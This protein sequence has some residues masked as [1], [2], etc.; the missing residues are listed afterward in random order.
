MTVLGVA[1]GIS[2][3]TENSWKASLWKG[4]AGNH[5]HG[6]GD[7]GK[8]QSPASRSSGGAFWDKSGART[9]GRLK[10]FPGLT[11]DAAEVGVGRL[12]ISRIRSGKCFL[13]SETLTVM[14]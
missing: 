10:T 7:C 9:R 1:H 13:W 5:S 12:G 4:A 2:A 14:V 6:R 11:A 3:S 8:V